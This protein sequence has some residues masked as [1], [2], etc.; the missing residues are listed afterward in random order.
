[1][2]RSGDVVGDLDVEIKLDDKGRFRA[3]AFSH[4]ADQYSNYLDNSQRNGLGLVYQEE[5][6]SFRELLN[7]L[8]TSRRKRERRTQKEKAMIKPREDEILNE[9]T[10]V[11]PL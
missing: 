2:D 5:F 6:S 11:S 3:K 8:F 1:M 7:S 9:A 4:S 10:I